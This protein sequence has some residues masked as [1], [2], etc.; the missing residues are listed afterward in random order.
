LVLV[1]PA[2]IADLRGQDWELGTLVANARYGTG[3]RPA[4]H[5]K[6]C[7]E[8]RILNAKDTI[9]VVV[10]AAPQQPPPEALALTVASHAGDDTV[11][12]LGQPDQGRDLSRR[13]ALRLH[14]HDVVA[15]RRVEAGRQG[16]IG[17]EAAGQPDEP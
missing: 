16:D 15:D 10:E 1:R 4:E 7:G 8:A 5:L 11:A 17:T 14:E 12:G 2:G 6:A 13:I 9:A 3:G